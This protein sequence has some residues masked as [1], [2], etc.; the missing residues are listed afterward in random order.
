M[1]MEIFIHKDCKHTNTHTHTQKYSDFFFFIRFNYKLIQQTI[2]NVSSELTIVFFNE[3]EERVFHDLGSESL[4]G[5]KQLIP[6]SGKDSNRHFAEMM[7][8]NCPV[9]FNKS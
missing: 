4:I 8:L 5:D 9:E 7:V 1:V 3:R 6:V 2:E